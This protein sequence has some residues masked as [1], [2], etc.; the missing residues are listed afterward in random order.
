MNYQDNIGKTIC[1]ALYYHPNINYY[2]IEEVDKNGYYETYTIRMSAFF[3]LTIPPPGKDDY[4][5]ILAALENQKR[6]VEDQEQ[7]EKL[8]AMQK[9]AQAKHY[10]EVLRCRLL[11]LPPPTPLTIHKDGSIEGSF[12]DLPF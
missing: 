10:I 8:Q 4:P 11:Q 7:K 2:S 12:D 1:V 3:D 6:N 5:A 9:A